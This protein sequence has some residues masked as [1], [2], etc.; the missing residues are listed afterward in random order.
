MTAWLGVAAAI[1][2]AAF[3][4]LAELAIVAAGRLR[5]RAW[6][7]Q[8][9]RGVEWVEGDPFERPLRLL[10][11]ILVGHTLTLA[12]AAMLAAWIV[13]RGGRGAFAAAGLTALLLVPPMYV[14]GEL[15][16]R[17]VARNRA[18][19][20]FPVLSLVLR[21]CGV[22]FRPLI[23][24]AD[25]ATGAILALIGSSAERRAALGRRS[26]ESLLAESERVGVVEPAE[27]EIIAGVF[28]FGET[29]ARA[30]MTPSV[31]MV[32][33]PAT[34][35]AED[36]VRIIRRTG[37]SRIPLHSGATD[38]VLGMVHVFDLFKLR[39][40]ERPR[41]RA[42]VYAHP[43]QPCDELL[44]EMKRRRCHMAIVRETGRAI[45]MV[46]LEDLIE[47]LV[48]EIHDEHD[49]RGRA[50]RGPRSFVVDS[51]ATA[52]DILGRHGVEVT[53]LGGDSVATLLADRLARKPRPGD[54]V[55]L[56]DWAI[57][58]LEVDDEGTGLARF[59]RR[60]PGPDSRS[61][62]GRRRSF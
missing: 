41:L 8:R 58:V 36:L 57:E 7:R 52:A 32:A 19:Q 22:V 20:L 21:A 15:L 47:E 60:P 40:D 42:V 14:L 34:A 2:V 48:G 46:T 61:L 53:A 26:L 18:H 44:L 54:V 59:R 23:I 62:S 13:T 10:S 27:R 37:F 17:V 5:V 28:D 49:R 50:A 12:T 31:R 25:I 29:T 11:P 43:D 35:R 56:G 6:V 9:M 38:R 39:R 3:F 24:A 51:T 45:G 4:S 33:A 1:V 55:D 16:P 30:V